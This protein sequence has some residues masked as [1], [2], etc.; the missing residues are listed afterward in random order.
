M[1]WT[2][3]NCDVCHTQDGCPSDG[4][5]TKPGGCVCT[6]D[7]DGTPCYIADNPPTL[8]AEY[9]A[10]YNK[11]REMNDVCK[12][13]NLELRQ[14]GLVAAPL[15]FDDEN[16]PFG[17]GQLPGIDTTPDDLLPSI[18]TDQTTEETTTLIIDLDDF[19]LA[20][21][22]GTTTQETTTQET[23][24][25]E[26]TTQG[27]TTQET[28]TQETTT[29]ETTTQ[30]ATTQETTQP[31]TQETTQP[32]TQPTTQEITTQ[33]ATTQETTQPTTQET[34]QETTQPT[35]QET[36]VD[37]TQESTT[38][39]V[40]TTTTQQTTQLTTEDPYNMDGD[41]IIDFHDDDSPD[42]KN[43]L[44]IGGRFMLPLLVQ[45]PQG[46]FFRNELWLVCRPV[47]SFALWERNQRRTA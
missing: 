6:S 36:T 32:T 18:S 31:T 13:V 10:N 33:E 46:Y 1:G 21:T 41:A 42:D 29:Q 38:L 47:W 14:Q 5:C 23:T 27:T 2:G 9:I 24:T 16:S 8:F 25:Q 28:T 37:T 40:D 44:D 7:Q 43:D 26:T 39:I 4:T 20:T 15:D 19:T 34:T 17:P 45:F 3:E 11:Q 35:T 12:S 22:Q 30:E